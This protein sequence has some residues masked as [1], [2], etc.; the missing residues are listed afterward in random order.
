MP[1]GDEWGSWAIYWGYAPT[2]NGSTPVVADTNWLKVG[3]SSQQ[4]VSERR[5]L[6]GKPH[7]SCSGHS[8]APK[9]NSHG[10][11]GKAWAD[12][13][14]DIRRIHVCAHSPCTEKGEDWG[15]GK[16]SELLIYM[17]RVCLDGG[18]SA[19]EACPFGEQLSASPP[20]VAAPAEAPTPVAEHLPIAALSD[21]PSV[22]GAV[23]RVGAALCVAH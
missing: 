15:F 19:S 18:V 3:A 5:A 17:C 21:A 13:G 16:L 20:P 1:N 22:W 12:D 10:T 4:C 23:V 6:Q 2:P 9:T 8:F 11:F 14:K 7:C